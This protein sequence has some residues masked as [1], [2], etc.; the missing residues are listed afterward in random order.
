MDNKHSNGAKNVQ[1]SVAY[2]ESLIEK[3]LRITG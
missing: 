3:S 2:T 1:N